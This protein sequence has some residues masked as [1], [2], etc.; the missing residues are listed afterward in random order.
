MATSGFLTRVNGDA[1]G[2]VYY[3][4]AAHGVTLGAPVAPAMARQPVFFKILP[5]VALDAETVTGGAVET[6]LRTIML[7][8][9]LYM[10]QVE[11]TTGQISVALDQSGWGQAPDAN[12]GQTTIT[13]AADLQ[14]A[15]VAL[16]SVG[17]GPVS[18][19][20]LTVVSEGFKL[21]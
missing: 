9:S 7:K 2:V 21:A 17:V 8:A 4:Q 12:N 18:L 14:A 5:N 6:I 11:A 20:G 16:G 3:D 1:N 13:G 15:L 10:Y 19:A